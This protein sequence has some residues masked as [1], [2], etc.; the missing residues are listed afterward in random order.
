MPAA[1]WLG[2]WRVILSDAQGVLQGILRG[3][4]YARL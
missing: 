3:L 1:F 4:E 2:V